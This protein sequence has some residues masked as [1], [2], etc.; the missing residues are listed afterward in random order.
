MGIGLPQFRLRQS[1]VIPN[2]FGERVCKQWVSCYASDMFR[3]TQCPPLPDRGLLIFLR[4]LH[5]SANLPQLEIQK[6]Q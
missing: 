4:L 2:H 3:Q 6:D 5:L 1:R